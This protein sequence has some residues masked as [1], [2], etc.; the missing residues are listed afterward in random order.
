VKSNTEKNIQLHND[1]KALEEEKAFVIK[2]KEDELDRCHEIIEELR[3]RAE[4]QEAAHQ[5]KNERLQLKLD[6]QIASRKATES[7]LTHFTET[8]NNV[9]AHNAETRK[10]ETRITDLQQELEKVRKAEA[11]SAATAKDLNDQMIALKQQNAQSE[12][13]L[14]DQMA[15]IVQSSAEIDDK[16]SEND[17]LSASL[18]QEKDAHQQTKQ[19]LNKLR[20]ELDAANTS[21]SIALQDVKQLSSNLEV[22]KRE[23]A[24]LAALLEQ[25]K[26]PAKQSN[27]SDAVM[28]EQ[29]VTIETLRLALEVASKSND[30]ESS[31]LIAVKDACKRHLTELHEAKLQ[32]SL[33]TQEL[34]GLK[35]QEQNAEHHVQ[36]LILQHSA[37][38]E[39]A[40]KSSTARLT[41]MHSFALTQK[42]N[43]LDAITE[44]LKASH[45]RENT[46]YDRIRTGQ[47]AI[48][49][50]EEVVRV[51][52]DE[53][54]RIQGLH[55]KQM[56]SHKDDLDSREAQQKEQKAQ[57]TTLMS[58]INNANILNE[59]QIMEN[60]ALKKLY[61]GLLERTEVHSRRDN[62]QLDLL[63][64]RYKDQIIALQNRLDQSH[65]VVGKSEAS[66]NEVLAR[67]KNME[68][69]L[70]RSVESR[71]KAELETVRKSSEL[72]YL[73]RDLQ[74]E[75]SRYKRL[76]TKYQQFSR[77]IIEQNSHR[78]VLEDVWKRSQHRFGGGVEQILDA[79]SL[80]DLTR[81]QSK[82]VKE[83]SEL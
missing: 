45:D 16:H 5:S 17:I 27:S 26:V 78:D 48:T 81:T 49:S 35:T 77:D 51:L 2:V 38:I 30:Q 55:E 60:T 41:Q 61:D 36:A 66:V 40:I 43:E 32:N 74:A 53:I 47:H 68:L 80:S 18:T 82:L 83:L 19:Q 7:K 8:Q 39:R 46:S 24:N 56:R 54:K 10:L 59:K 22:E 57:Y 76:S 62:A 73:Q 37:D 25:S 3:V 14:L 65:S 52:Q 31:S 72:E 34:A 11:E 6:E 21:R 63:E 15:R 44:A 20:S 58:Q 42:Q 33:L 71:Y 79:S 9:E 67:L 12:E 29:Q 64:S 28:A 23:R 1:L 75:K 4:S 50:H 69:Q 70:E 13:E